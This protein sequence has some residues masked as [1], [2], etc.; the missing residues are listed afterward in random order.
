MSPSGLDHV[1]QDP[2]SIRSAFLESP[3]PCKRLDSQYLKCMKRKKE[4]LKCLP[5]RDQLLQCVAEKTPSKNC[6]A[7]ELEE[8]N[9]CYNMLVGMGYYQ[10]PSGKTVLHCNDYGERLR[11]CMR[12]E[13]GLLV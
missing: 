11:K 3:P 8:Y 4:E 6:K 5:E 9:K 12:G 1:L 10:E 13:G 7:I 2:D